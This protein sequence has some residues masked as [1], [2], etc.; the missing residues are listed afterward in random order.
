MRISH[1]I[2]YNK[3]WRP[4]SRLDCNIVWLNLISV[5]FWKFNVHPLSRLFF[6]AAE[7]IVPFFGCSLW[8][9]DESQLPDIHTLSSD[10][11]MQSF[12]LLHTC[13]REIQPLHV[14]CAVEHFMLLTTYNHT[15]QSNKR[16]KSCIVRHLLSHRTF[17]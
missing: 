3:E 15:H 8:S 12:S 14:V 10:S 2:I 6:V 16:R 9:V 5:K 4:R 11:S 1:I 13:C 7:L 17:P